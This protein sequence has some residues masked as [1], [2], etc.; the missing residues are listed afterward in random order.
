MVQP[1]ADTLSSDRNLSQASQQL[2]RGDLTASM[3]LSAG[4]T[5]LFGR[6]LGMVQP[7]AD[8]LSSDRNLSQGRSRGS[9]T[10]T[11]TRFRAWAS[12]A[13]SSTGA[14]MSARSFRRT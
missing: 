11:R 6:N 9:W 14:W 2:Y 5:T 1:G 12:A 10:F 8:T 4:L 3:H 7:G 13:S